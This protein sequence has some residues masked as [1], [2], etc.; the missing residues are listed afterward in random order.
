MNSCYFSNFVHLYRLKDKP[1]SPPWSTYTY[2]STILFNS[3]IGGFYTTA[4]L[5]PF[6]ILCIR[7][8]KN[9][10]ILMEEY[11]PMFHNI[12]RSPPPIA[13]PRPPK[14]LKVFY[15]SYL[16]CYMHLLMWS[17]DHRALY[18]GGFSM[19]ARYS[20]M[21]ALHYTLYDGLR[22]Y[23]DDS[24]STISRHIETSMNYIQDL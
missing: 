11:D 14:S 9:Y 13:G 2:I 20:I 22:K 15:S 21:Y 17:E 3:I 6:D 12:Y 23:C 24:A 10:P 18:L 16:D 4:F 19:W 8:M 5:A 1:T 7:M